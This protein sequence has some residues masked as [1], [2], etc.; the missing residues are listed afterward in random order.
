MDNQSIVEVVFSN[1]SGIITAIGGFAAAYYA[2]VIKRKTGEQKTI[3]QLQEHVALL[4]ER[5]AK[6]DKTISEMQEQNVK[7][8]S[9]IQTLTYKL[10]NMDEDLGELRETLALE[11]KEK[12]LYQE[13][14][15]AE[16]L[17]K[18]RILDENKKMLLDIERLKSEVRTL[19][20]QLGMHMD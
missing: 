12:T 15:Q 13:K 20:S 9:S 6:K 17:E 2:F 7:Q 18:M 4:M 3:A 16:R 19:K 8:V 1:L 10:E 11:R 14:Y 5:D